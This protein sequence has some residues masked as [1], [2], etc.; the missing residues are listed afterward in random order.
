MGKK[1]AHELKNPTYPYGDINFLP[2]NPWVNLW[3]LYLSLWGVWQQILP[4]RFRAGQ[5]LPNAKRIIEIRFTYFEKM[6][7]LSW[8]PQN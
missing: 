5:G 8:I 3:R 6:L 2:Y 7:F 4:P 1:T